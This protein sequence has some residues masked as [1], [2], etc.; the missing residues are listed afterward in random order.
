[1]RRRSISALLDEL[2]RCELLGIDALVVHPG[3]HISGSIEA[4]VRLVSRS[5]DAIHRRRAGYR[6]TILLETTAGQGTSI[7]HRFEHLAAIRGLIME[8][9]RVG[10]C[11]DTC[12][13]FAAGYDFRTLQAY[14]AMISELESVINLSAVGC[15]HLNDSRRPLGSRVDRH[16]HIGK[17]KIGKRG[18]ANFLNDPR[19]ADVPMIL[20][21]PKGKDGRGTDF[22][23]VNLKRL[24]KL[25]QSDTTNPASQD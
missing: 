24:R 10:V 6:T 1:M 21:T 25:L 18:F 22:D 14:K 5:L 12:H 11:L 23:M 19:F 20:E 8:P 17:G 15:I 16:E 13:L 2:Q 9:C 3:S 7:G 4:G